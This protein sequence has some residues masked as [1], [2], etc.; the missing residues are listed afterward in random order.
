MVTRN[1]RTNAGAVELPDS[2]VFV[3]TYFFVRVAASSNYHVFQIDRP[4][5]LSH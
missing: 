3:R 4:E 1:D 2:E 5:K